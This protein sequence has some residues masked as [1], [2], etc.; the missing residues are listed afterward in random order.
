MGTMTPYN[1]TA[2]NSDVTIGRNTEASFSLPCGFLVF[3]LNGF[4]VENVFEMISA[5]AHVRA[6]DF[7]GRS[8]SIGG[9]FGSPFRL[10]FDESPTRDRAN[11]ESASLRGARIERVARACRE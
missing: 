5:P 2:L 7:A 11:H 4:S 9:S 3:A 6:S 10:D 8:C 1:A